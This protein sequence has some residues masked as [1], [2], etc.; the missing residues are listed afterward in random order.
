MDTAIRV[1]ADLEKA[2]GKKLANNL[3][4]VARSPQMKRLPS[5]VQFRKQKPQF[6]LGDNGDTLHAYG[7]DISTGEITG[8]VYCGSADTI[9]NH[10]HQQQSEGL[11]APEGKAIIFVHS[12]WNGRNH[13]WSVTVVSNNFVAQV[14]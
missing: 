4:K 14:S 13:S 7:A 8:E 3:I 5:G 1:K 11:E 9:L 10:F 12:Y 2:L 6:C